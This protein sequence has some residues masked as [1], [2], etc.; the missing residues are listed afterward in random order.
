MRKELVS[1]AAA[2]LCGMSKHRHI[3]LTEEQRSE[4]DQLIQI[5]NALACTHTRARVLLLNDRG[6]GQK[7]TDQDV[8]DA[9]LCSQSTVGNGRLGQG[10]DIP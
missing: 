7:R 4:L 3:E 1:D 10:G 2:T 9:A 6:H 5:G 8:A